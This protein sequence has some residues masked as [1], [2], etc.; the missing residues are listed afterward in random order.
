MADPK[1]NESFCSMRYEGDASDGEPDGPYLC[2]G[3]KDDRSVCPRAMRRRAAK[4][5]RL[6][7][8]MDEYQVTRFGCVE[9]K[10]VREARAAAARITKKSEKARRK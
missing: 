4:L 3:D 6:I 5:E 8:A 7:V 2:G 10:Q 9:N 1:C